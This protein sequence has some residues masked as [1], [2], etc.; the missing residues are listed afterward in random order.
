VRYDGVSCVYEVNARA[1]RCQTHPLPDPLLQRVADALGDRSLDHC[2][3]HTWTEPHCVLW[4]KDPERERDLG[5][6]ARCALAATQRL[7]RAYRE[8][9]AGSAAW[10]VARGRSRGSRAADLPPVPGISK[11]RGV[12]GFSR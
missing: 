11:D 6:A 7:G 3:P 2:R 9:L 4:E 8:G 5:A 10:D 12:P 1:G